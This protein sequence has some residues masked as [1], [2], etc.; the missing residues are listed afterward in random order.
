MMILKSVLN[1][2]PP[3]SRFTHSNL[4]ALVA[5][6]INIAVLSVFFSLTAKL[7]SILVAFNYFSLYICNRFSGG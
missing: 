6:S 7:G 1:S 2:Y 3:G 5:L 4:A